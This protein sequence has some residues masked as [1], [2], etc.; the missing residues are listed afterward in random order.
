MADGA[1]GDQPGGTSHFIC[2]LSEF[3]GGVA[4]SVVDAGEFAPRDELTHFRKFSF[5]APTSA[6]FPRILKNAI[7][8]SSDAMAPIMRP[9]LLE[10]PFSGCPVISTIAISPRAVGNC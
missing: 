1:A 4:K 10:S 3:A 6:E 9:S 8:P 7:R 2:G 5:C